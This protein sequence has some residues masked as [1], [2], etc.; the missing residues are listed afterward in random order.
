MAN[1]LFKSLM[2]KP[3]RCYN[4]SKGGLQRMSLY[5]QSCRLT[6]TDKVIQNWLTSM[7]IIN[8]THVNK[9]HLHNYKQATFAS[10]SILYNL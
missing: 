5:R 6:G 4:R 8:C 2:R 1:N 3:E 9:I 10:L 7:A